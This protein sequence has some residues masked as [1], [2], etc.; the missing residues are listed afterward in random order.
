M[1][2]RCSRASSPIRRSRTPEKDGF[3][4]PTPLDFEPRARAALADAGLQRALAGLPGGLVAERAAA[5]ARLPEF[6]ALRDAARDIRDHTL[7][8]L[9]LY[10]RAFERRAAAAGD[11]GH[12]AA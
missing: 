8:N 11:P 7:A 6:E 3:M 12:F 5:K 1:S 4:T 9:A 10:L 2:P